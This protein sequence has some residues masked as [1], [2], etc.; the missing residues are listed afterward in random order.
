MQAQEEEHQGQVQTKRLRLSR[1]Q[2][3]IISAVTVGVAGTGLVIGFNVFG[4]QSKGGKGGASS[5]APNAWVRIDA[6]NTVTI[7]V[8]KS[9]MGQGVMTALPMLLAEE[10]DADWSKVRVEQPNADVQ[11]GDQLT[12]GSSSVSDS[13]S[14]MRD[15]GS[16][17]RALLIAAAAQTWGVKQSTCRTEKSM[18]IHIPTGKRLP[19]G[20]LVGLASTLPMNADNLASL[21]QKQPTEFTLIGTRTPR[22]DSPQKTDGSA[23]FG[24]DVRVPGMRYATVA[25]C[26]YLG[27]SLDHMD[28]TKASSTPGVLKVLQI[29]SGIA[30]VAENTWAAIQ[31]RQALEITW[32]PG[33]NA[34]FSSA[35]L[36]SQL[37]AQ[38]QSLVGSNTGTG[39][40]IE[41][42]YETP[43]LAHATMEPMNCT[44]DV[45]ATRCEVW[46]PT[47]APQQAQQVAATESGLPLKAV[48]LH[49]TFA[50]GGFGRRTYTDFVAEA[51]QVSKAIGAPVQ[52]VLDPR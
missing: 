4:K 50:G 37:A 49:V 19:Y 6:D 1:R 13:F 15:A 38:V 42:V 27:G 11:Y 3:L 22:V 7:Q 26:P 39:K 43:F 18:V 28:S 29:K 9:E 35:Q 14:P 16:V 25:R 12:D 32:N 34:Q 40:T 20:D 2:F 17:A 30:V 41:A 36:Q 44:A 10:L 24:L 23:R 46:A 52:V 51:V 31:G 33:P 8:G 21:R 47:Q 48:T 45:Q 5:F